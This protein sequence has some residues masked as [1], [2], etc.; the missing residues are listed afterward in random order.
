M[1][2]VQ[3]TAAFLYFPS[4]C[5]CKE[6]IT[7]NISIALSGSSTTFVMNIIAFMINITS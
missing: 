2:F 3:L 6:L 7:L 1:A 5:T 4:V